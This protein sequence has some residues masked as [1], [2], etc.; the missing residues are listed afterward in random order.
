MGSKIR[1]IIVAALLAA[2]CTDG[3]VYH[4]YHSTGS[5]SW[6]RNDT[7][8]FALPASPTGEDLVCSL[9]VGLRIERLFPYESLCIATEEIRDSAVVHR[10]T[11]TFHFADQH[12]NL[13]NSG[14]RLLQFE[15]P[16]G[17]VT[18]RPSGEGEMRLYHIMTRET[19]PHITDAGIRVVRKGN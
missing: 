1:S 8:Q 9:Y 13:I 18:L 7:L 16:A 11:V 15:V 14:I 6:N 10:D 19:V 12:G 2:G 17:L 5:R 3:T 4:A